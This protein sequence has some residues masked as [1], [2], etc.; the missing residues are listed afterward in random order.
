MTEQLPSGAQPRPTEPQRA[1]SP[2][3]GWAPAPLSGERAAL[4]GR[5]PGPEQVTTPL[6]APAP[7]SVNI[8][9]FAPPRSRLPLVVTLVALLA[10]ALIWAGTT[11]RPPAPGPGAT[12]SAPTASPA[13]PGL[14]F[15]TPDER[16]SGRWEIL[17]HRWTDAGLEAKIRIA[18]D[19]GPIGV[20]FVAFENSGVYA[21]EAQEG[22]QPPTF[23]GLPIPSGESETGWVH[24]PMNRGPATIILTTA[25]GNQM[26]ALP[27]PG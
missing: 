15:L 27:V 21:T 9:Q 11:L 12:P 22:S 8:D 14:P 13:A 3:P 10:A 24:F 19:R 1:A 23:S 26:S 17:E 5:P 4:G 6:G 16:Y 7:D 18:V 2:P 20:A 25:I